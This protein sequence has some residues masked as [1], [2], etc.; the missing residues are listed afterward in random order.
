MMRPFETLQ[1][2]QLHHVRVTHTNRFSLHA[3][4]RISDYLLKQLRVIST[5]QVADIHKFSKY[6][7]A[8]HIFA[9]NLRQ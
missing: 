8:R 2:I 5:A 3:N 4:I 9:T 7:S 6:F 1:T